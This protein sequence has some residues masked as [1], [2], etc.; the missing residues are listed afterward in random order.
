MMAEKDSSEVQIAID[1]A[2]HLAYPC[3]SE[4]YPDLNLRQH[5][6]RLAGEILP[7]LEDETAKSILR[8][9]IE[10]YK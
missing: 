8:S 9:A 10:R 3:S 4:S 5:H 2:N 7:T 1:M 6:L